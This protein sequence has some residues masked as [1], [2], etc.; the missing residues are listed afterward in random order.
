MYEVLLSGRARRFFEDAAAELQRRLDRCFEQ[1]RR[2]PRRHAN[3]K[4]LKGKLDGYYRYRVGDHRVVYSINDRDQTVI[5][6][7]IANRRDVYDR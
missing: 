6:A 5:V 7:V 2:D 3:I 1:L 4:R